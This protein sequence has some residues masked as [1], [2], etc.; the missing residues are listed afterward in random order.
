MASDTNI[1]EEQWYDRT[2]LMLGHESFAKMQN[3]HVVVVGVGGVGGY[4]AEM[5]VRSGVGKITIIDSDNVSLTNINRQLIACHE[6]VGI[7]KVELFKKRFLRINPDL[8]VNA[9]HCYLT[10]E[11]ITNF[12]NEKVDFVIDAIDTVGPK[13]SLIEY[14]IKNKVN[15]ISSMGAGGRV[16]P[17][18]IK[19]CDIWET[20]EDGLARVVRQRLRKIGLRCKLPV[21]CSMELPKRYSIIELNEENKRSSFG[22]LATIP[23]I[24]GIYLANYVIRKLTGI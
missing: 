17:S 5:L 15:I 9:E 13:V 20:K 24:F 1:A 21:V 14:C 22:T 4:A 16:D 10:S 6:T 18:M 2:L 12:I 8:E 23:S 7:S 3:A 19:Y 11:N